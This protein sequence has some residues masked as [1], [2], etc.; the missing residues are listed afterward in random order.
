M[1]TIL[2]I[3][4]GLLFVILYAD[5]QQLKRQRDHFIKVSENLLQEL[6]KIGAL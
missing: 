2:E 4:A 5:R 1:R 3:I 6:R